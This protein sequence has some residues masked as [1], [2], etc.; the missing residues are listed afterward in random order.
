VHFQPA[1]NGFVPRG[2]HHTIDELV[3]MT[4][5]GLPDYADPAICPVLF[6]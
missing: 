5:T 3:S 2:C 6:P 4:G 1:T